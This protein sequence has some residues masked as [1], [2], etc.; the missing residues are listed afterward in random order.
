MLSI[1]GPSFS[2]VPRLPELAPQ[3]DRRPTGT[4]PAADGGMVSTYGRSMHRSLTPSAPWRLL[5]VPLLAA[6]ACTQPEPAAEPAMSPVERG[7]Y[8]ANQ[9][10]CDDCHTPKIFTAQ[11]PVLDSARRLSGSPAGAV[12]PAIPPGVLG[13]D[14]WGALASNDLTVW[15]GPWGVS[16]GANLTPDA[17]G[18]AG[19][20]PEIFIAAMR[21]GKHAGAG[22]PILPPMPWE[23]TGRLTDED[24]RALFAYLASLPPVANQV[25]APIPPA[26][27]AG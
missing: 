11:G 9:G 16:F 5:A 27:P 15:V 22:R 20:T 2:L 3:H 26:G 10:H 13:P 19:W 7:A 14:G 4:L 18:L 21:T 17:T 24:L 1:A 12:V 6:V 23:L 8:L 25:P